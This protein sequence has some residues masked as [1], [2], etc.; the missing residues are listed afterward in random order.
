LRAESTLDQGAGW[1]KR[2]V[3]ARSFGLRISLVDGTGH[4]A[5]EGED[6]PPIA[7]MG[8]H[9]SPRGAWTPQR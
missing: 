5:V 6:T 1:Q 4:S 9:H 2:L 3:R 7:T 8:P